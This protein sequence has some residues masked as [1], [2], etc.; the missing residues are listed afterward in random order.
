MEILV[1]EL[2]LSALWLISSILVWRPIYA[3]KK[4][5][6][7]CTFKTIY[8]PVSKFIQHFDQFIDEPASLWPTS[9]GH[10]PGDSGT[11]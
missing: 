7:H 5:T 9:V 3:D 4:F 11:P 8:L 10:V 1:L 2:P 6:V